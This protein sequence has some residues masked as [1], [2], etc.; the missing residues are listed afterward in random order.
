[1]NILNKKKFDTQG[2]TQTKPRQRPSQDDACEHYLVD[3]QRK[4][5]NYALKDFSADLS[6]GTRGERLNCTV[7]TPRKLDRQT[8]RCETW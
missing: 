1:M 8:D 2:L 3:V 4:L 6:Q 7:W 5:T